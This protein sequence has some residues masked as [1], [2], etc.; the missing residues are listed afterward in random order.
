MR[1]QLTGPLQDLREDLLAVARDTESLLK[2]TA[3]ATGD[4][5]QQARSQAQDSLHRAF[6]HLYDR[7]IRKRVRKALK[8]ADGYVQD[9]TWAMIG[10]AAAVGM[11][12]GLLVKRD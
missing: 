12:F 11:L 9:N 7:R 3:N 6:D 4:Q 2:A 1:T 10:A 5:I 8:T